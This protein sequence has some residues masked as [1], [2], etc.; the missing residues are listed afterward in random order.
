MDHAVK[1]N[2]CN[3]FWMADYRRFPRGSSTGYHTPEPTEN[4]M[5]RRS[6]AAREAIKGRHRKA[7]KTKRHDASETAS[8]SAPV[9]DAEVR[10][11]HSRTERG[12]GAT[13]GDLGGA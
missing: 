3:I 12:V 4:A 9:Y 2:R 10:S 5:K 11:A 1:P 6:R 8:S 13:S 7:L